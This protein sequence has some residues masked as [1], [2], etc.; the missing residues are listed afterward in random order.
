MEFY[1]FILVKRESVTIC[2]L[3]SIFR[4]GWMFYNR[5]QDWG[6]NPFSMCKG[7]RFLFTGHTQAFFSIPPTACLARLVWSQ[8]GEKGEIKREFGCF[9]KAYPN[10][11]ALQSR[12]A[13]L[14]LGSF[15]S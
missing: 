2:F 10:P 13:K 8:K 3:G 9:I 15:L 5:A 14:A 4:Y 6:K 7:V 11:A 1:L 12:A